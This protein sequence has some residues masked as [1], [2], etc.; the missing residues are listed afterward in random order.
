MLLRH[1]SSTLPLSSVNN[2]VRRRKPSAS[3]ILFGSLHPRSSLLATSRCPSSRLVQSAFFVNAQHS[4]WT[5]TRSHFALQRIAP[6][7]KVF[8][9]RYLVASAL[10]YE[11]Q[12]TFPKV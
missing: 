4:P 2:I 3:S 10:P 7:W 11:P 8:G 9:P 6:V 5:R 1:R 12:S